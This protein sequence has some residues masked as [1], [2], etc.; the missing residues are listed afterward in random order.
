MQ[1]R[2]LHILKYLE[3]D[4]EDSSL[5][6]RWFEP[7]QCNESWS[8]A[9]SQTNISIWLHPATQTTLYFEHMSGRR[10]YSIYSLYKVTR[11]QHRETC[12]FLQRLSWEACGSLSALWVH[13]RDK[14][15]CE[16][17]LFAT[18]IMVNGGIIA[19]R[20]REVM[21]WGRAEE[22]TV[23][24]MCSRGEMTSPPLPLPPS[25]HGSQTKCFPLNCAISPCPRPY[26]IV[27]ASRLTRSRQPLFPSPELSIK[28]LPRSPLH[29][30]YLFNLWGN[31]PPRQRAPVT[32]YGR[33]ETAWTAAVVPM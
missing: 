2:G 28:S 30:S 1:P 29:I 22:N 8:Y 15:V 12:W 11:R 18:Y 10:L 16:W 27:S 9:V 24:W 25:L 5:R 32:G 20:E 4:P 3:R 23:K 14:Y 7:F 17:R 13:R 26:I 21:S 19:G 6:T 31:H 33:K